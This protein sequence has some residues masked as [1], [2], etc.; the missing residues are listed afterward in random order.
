MKI[1]KHIPHLVIATILFLFVSCEDFLTEVPQSEYSVAGSYTTQKDFESGIAAC[2]DVI[3]DLHRPFQSWFRVNQGRGDEYLN[4][5]NFDGF[6][7]FTVDETSKMALFGWQSFF[8]IITYANT[9]LDNIENGNF[10]DLKRK[11]HI[12]GEA[13]M[14]RAYAYYSLGWNFGGV[15]LYDKFYATEDILNIA[16]SS[17]EETFAF[18]E[19]DYLKAISLLPEAWDNSN[20]GRTTKFA[21]QAMLGRMYMFQKKEALAKPLFESVINSGKHGFADKY[22][23]VFNDAFD[24]TKERIWEAQFT[25]G[26]LGEGTGS[27]F[28]QLP[29]GV[30]DPEYAPV[31]GGTG[32]V[33]V[34]DTL[35]NRYQDGDLRRDLS[36]LNNPR[37]FGLVDNISKFVVKFS[38]FT[39]KP[40]DNLDYANNLPI[41]RY[42]D[43][44]L[45]YAEI[46]N[47]EGYTANGKA[48]EIL[49]KV[50]ERA[51]L[52]PLNSS[53]TPNQQAF[54]DAL[55]QERKFEFAFEGIR[56]RD[57]LRWGIAQETMNF[58]FDT[59]LITAGWS[60]E[61]H[62]KI[63]PIPFETLSR[64]D[65]TSIMFQ[66]P[67]Y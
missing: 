28:T 19:K 27:I 42:T 32:A 39:Y 57:L 40:K 49:N 67:G 41:I 18:A 4:G 16:R 65:N 47:N 17:Q 8:K 34:S 51:G 63:L 6:K 25:G 37:I 66:N 31:G 21:A 59:E 30:F 44:A 64:Y 50:R 5:S 29:L 33:R 24:N 11:D 9:V 23:D 45:Q 53:T 36:I 10:F 1:K 14:M 52:T 43:V 58:H 15:P 35:Y 20:R 38:K 22:E 3:Q 60:M 61:D 54:T 48:F 26:Q 13:Y 55:R 56:W 46:L 7:N 2:Y 12:K 62:N